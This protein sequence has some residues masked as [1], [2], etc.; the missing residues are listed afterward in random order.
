[1]T[2][3][4]RLFEQA[5]FARVHD[6]C[7]RAFTPVHEGFERVLGS[8]IF[9]REYPGWQAR[10]ADDIRNLVAAAPS[11]LVHVIED[12]GQVVG[13]VATILHADRK[14]G[15]IGLNAIDPPHQGRGAGK[16][17]YAFALGSLKQRGAEHAYVGTGA[18]AAHAPARAA[19]EAMGF[20][21]LI[22]SHHYF[23]KL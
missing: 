12:A 23:R 2:R 14:C 22:P 6:I 13:F 15:E 21:L 9:A 17:M 19:Y 8:E 1:M 4:I 5:D 3:R 10:Y 7:V 16:E 20:D 18:D 11:T